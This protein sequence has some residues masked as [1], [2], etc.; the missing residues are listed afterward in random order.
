MYFDGASNQYSYGIGVLLIAPDNSLIPLA[1][2]LQFKVSNNEAEYE[3]CITGLEATLELAVKRLDVIGNSNPVVS[4]AKGDWKVKEEKMKIYHQTLD[5]LIP[6]FEKLN[7]THLLRENN[8]FVDSLATLSS[9]IDIPFGVRMR[10]IIIEQKFVPAYE[11]LAAI[12]EVQDESPW[13][14]DVWNFL[15]KE[16]GCF[17]PETPTARCCQWGNSS[18]SSSK[19]Q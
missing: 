6:R 19:G 16:A 18:H 8:R 12:E 9:M 2:K 14:Y 1:F 15:E 13:Y 10:P 3:T 5:V 4:Q 7:F 17:Q 11:L